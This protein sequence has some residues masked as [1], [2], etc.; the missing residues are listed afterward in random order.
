MD[1]VCY[2]VDIYLVLRII[3]GNKFKR[4]SFV[5]NLVIIFGFECNGKWGW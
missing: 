5:M 4:L 1:S 3:L 2:M